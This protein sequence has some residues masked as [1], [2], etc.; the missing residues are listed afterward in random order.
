MPSNELTNCSLGSWLRW[1]RAKLSRPLTW[2]T[3]ISGGLKTKTA[4]LTLSSRSRRMCWSKP[5]RSVIMRDE[6]IGPLHGVPLNK[7]HD[8]HRRIRTTSGSQVRKDS[9][10]LPTRLR[11]NAESRWRDYPRQNQHAGNGDPYRQT[12]IFGR[13][14]NPYDKRLTS[15]GSSAGK[16][17]RLRLGCLQEVWVVLVGFDRVPHILRHR[18]LKPTSGRIRWMVM[19][20]LLEE[21][22]PMRLVWVRWLERCRC[23]S[24]F[25]CWLVRE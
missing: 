18:G 7:R 14:N 22:W 8:C 5:S 1:S 6:S 3:P 4:P 16:Q 25:V 21:R 23:F 15:G 10:P 12:S 17:Q 11:S 20:R 2:S 19:F 13:T 24:L 9:F